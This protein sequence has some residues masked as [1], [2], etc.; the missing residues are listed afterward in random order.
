MPKGVYVHKPHQALNFKTFKHG[1]CG[2]TRTPTYYTWQCMKERCNS[3]SH[4]SFKY[5]GGRGIRVCEKWNTFE[6]F[7]NDMGIRP[8]G[9]YLDRIDSNGNY[10]PSNCKWSTMKE[11][12]NN[13][14][15]NVRNKEMAVA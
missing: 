12:Q 14:R 10:E 13:R 4:R 7:L 1:H 8:D 11:Q 15:N 2:T 9:K 3:Q 6:S 5:Y